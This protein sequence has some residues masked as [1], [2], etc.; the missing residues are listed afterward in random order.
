MRALAVWF[1]CL[2]LL[3][4]ACVASRADWNPGES[5]GKWIQMPDLSTNGMDIDCTAA[6]ILADD[7]E[8]S[9]TG[10][11]TNIHIW[12]S[13]RSDVLPGGDSGQVSFTLS[14]HADIPAQGE[15]HS[16]P[17]AVLWYTNFVPGQFKVVEYA[18]GLQEWWMTP[19]QLPVFPGD[20]VCWQYNFAID[21]EDAFVQQG[22]EQE[23]VVY[24]LDVQ[25]F[26]LGGTGVEAF[27]WKTST[28]HW[29]DDATSGQG[30]EPYTGAWNELLYPP[31]HPMGP[32]NSIDLAFVI[33]SGMSE[34]P[35]PA[36]P[37]VKWLQPLD[38]ENGIDVPSYAS[39][40]A[41]ELIADDFVSDGRPIA[42][43][44]FWGSYLGWAT[45][46]P[47]LDP[48]PPPGGLYAPVAYRFYWFS[49]AP[50]G[51]LAAYSMP[52]DTIRMDRYTTSMVSASYYTSIWH[53]AESGDGWWEHEYVYE[54]MFTNTWNEKEGTV[55]WLGIQAV[56]E[57]TAEALYPWGWATTPLEHGWNDDAVRQSLLGD[58]VILSETFSGGA[59][60]AGW[61]NL[62]HVGSAAWRVGSTDS[63]S[64]ASPGNET[65]YTGGSGDYA[66]ADSD[67][68]EGQMD[69]ELWT[70]PMNLSAF[71]APQLTF[72]SDIRDAEN[73]DTFDVDVSVNGGSSWQP[74]LARSG[75][76]YF[77][78]EQIRIDLTA[79]AGQPDVR[80]R[81][82]Y[83]SPGWHLWWQV[84]DITVKELWYR[85]LYYD[86]LY[87]WHPCGHES[88][89]MAFALITDVSGRRAR[90]W[91]QPPDMT[92]GENMPTFL[93]PSAP[94][95]IV[96]ADDFIS[97]GRR[98]TDI[99]WWGSYL[100]YAT[101]EPGP[102]EPPS[103]SH[104]RPAG[105]HL[106]W[107]TDIPADASGQGYSMPGDLL[108]NIFI[109]F[110]LC[111]EVYFGTVTQEWK[112]P[113]YFEHE[114]QYYVDLLNT[115]IPMDGAW[116]EQRGTT[117]WLNIQAELDVEWGGQEHAGWGWKTTPP[118]YHWNDY[119]VVSLDG[120]S[121]WQR[122]DYPAGHPFSHPDPE[123][124]FCDLA[125]EL[126]TD[127]VGT[128]QW[129]APIVFTN[130]TC[131]DTNGQITLLSVGDWG[132]GKQ[133]LESCSDLMLTNW[134]SIMVNPLP[135]PAP[136][137]NTWHWTNAFGSNEFYRIRQK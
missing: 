111:H 99:H 130:M 90:K 85:E 79:F 55:Y 30:E 119:S 115:N 98:I 72:R 70:P 113:E 40:G 67:N 16:R 26:P 120:G 105:F 39:E 51:M 97:D 82:H 125:F 50:T 7:F 71:I 124:G 88:V 89:D 2:L 35:P 32:T 74:L 114:F 86:D 43:L 12:G 75:A 4:I 18:S 11:I 122:G 45:N 112:H 5:G 77:G 31:E 133:Y 28:T 46:T 49:D 128:N 91:D 117:Y 131:V 19:G 58:T 84:D 15:E 107:H 68:A 61:T 41:T 104:S 42:G 59:I 62:A 33:E 10:P 132:S 80:L 64:G 36:S 9:V 22:T 103:G 34:E 123:Q 3:T 56:Y 92:F 137:V 14:L 29:N 136:W 81:F 95:G 8:C 24:W 96:R 65:N 87:A 94:P 21:P 106:S 102:V 134:S 6:S 44:R 52:Q 37:Y 54:V 47:P 17:G 109:P 101:N 78:P 23:P 69:A 135:Y 100:G 83:V 53:Q 48:I 116:Y 63:A 66:D 108:T 25:A 73:A 27:G 126:T 121:T 110:G 1:A 13:W 127:E 60:P 20:E 76:D 118:E 129:Y 93:K 38:H 57:P